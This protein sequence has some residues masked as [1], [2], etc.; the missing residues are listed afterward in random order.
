MTSALEVYLKQ[1]RELVETSLQRVLPGGTP[2]GLSEACM[3]VCSD[4]RRDAPIAVGGP[5]QRV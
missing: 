5:G 1:R 2:A 3:T 4:T